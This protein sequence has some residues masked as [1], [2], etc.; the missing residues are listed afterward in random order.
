MPSFYT[1]VVIIAIIILIIALSLIGVTLA[2]NENQKPYPEYENTCPD[3]WVLENGNL[4]K[5]QGVNNVKPEKVEK[6]SQHSGINITEND[7]VKEIESINISADNWM[8]VCDKS[9]WAKKYDI[10]WDG[11]TNNN[12]CA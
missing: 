9:A 1:I 4:C 10:L 11:V 3:F 8:S 2:K 5:P 6:A 7:G 12:N